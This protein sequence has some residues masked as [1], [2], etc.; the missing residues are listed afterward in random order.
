[1][2]VL[3]LFLAAGCILMGVS[4]FTVGWDIIPSPFT[5]KKEFIGLII[6][7]YVMGLSLISL[8]LII[9]TC[10]FDIYTWKKITFEILLIVIFV[11]CQKLVILR[12]Q[13]VINSQSN[14]IQLKEEIKEY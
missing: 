6:F 11:I 13:K 3:T 10:I 14:N 1:M 8:S 7:K 9:L 5:I 4:T 2:D 12:V